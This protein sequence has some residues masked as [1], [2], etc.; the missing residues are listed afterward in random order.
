[1]A[2]VACDLVPVQWRKPCRLNGYISHGLVN[3]ADPAYPQ[4]LGRDEKILRRVHL[5]EVGMSAARLQAGEHMY[6][7]AFVR[8]S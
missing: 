1:M 5:S 8:Q 7:R 2:R 6:R 4:Q 3:A